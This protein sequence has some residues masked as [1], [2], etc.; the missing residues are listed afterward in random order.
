MKFN[1]DNIWIFL[2]NIPNILKEAFVWLLISYLIPLINIGIIWGMTY[3]LYNYSL[4]ICSIVLATNAC[5]YTSLIYLIGDKKKD[6][7]NN[8]RNL[9]NIV[10][11]SFFAITIGL[12]SVSIIELQKKETILHHSFY[13]I[14]SLISF[15]ICVLAAIVSK[16]DEDSAKGKERAKESKNVTTTNVDGK[17]IDI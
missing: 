5:F 11:I 1:W 16:Y 17:N 2:K 12:F 7:Q 15:A 4:D 8:D 13:T 14:G 9:I 6:E 10:N 3:P